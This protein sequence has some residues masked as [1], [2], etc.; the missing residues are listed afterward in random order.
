MN[1]PSNIT[2]TI[3]GVLLTLVSLWYGQNHGLL[4]VAATEEA[5][6]VDNLFN[7]M[8][9]ISTGLFL[10]V[11]GLLVFSLFR[12][13]RRKDDNTDGPPVHG[14]VPLEIFWTA[15]PAVVVLWLSI[16]SFDVYK[17]EG[18]MNPMEHSV[19]H[20]AST[21]DQ[22]AQMPGAALAAPLPEPVETGPA[23]EIQN[24][25][26]QEKATQDPATANVRNEDVPQK[27][28]A[29][30]LGIVSPGVG[31]SPKNR[32]KSPEL[33]VNV[34]GLQYAWIFTYP[35]SGVISGDLH[36]PVGRE[37]RLTMTANDVIHAFWVPE[38]R[39]K[40]DV[41]PGRQTELRFTPKTAGEYSVICAELC[42]AYHS[43]M[44][45]RVI[46]QSPKEY[47]NWL[48]SRKVAANS[49]AQIVAANPTEQS[50]SEF[51]TPHAEAMGFESEIIAP[52]V[53]DSA[54]RGLNARENLQEISDHL[55]SHHHSL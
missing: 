32:G 49:S 41:I 47:D 17:A 27:R 28:E 6:Q 31:A 35:D 50:P 37:V 51:L 38:F 16:Y 36:V 29:S 9:S 46:T 55:A 43:I 25:Q 15:I 2:T 18:G 22:V 54:T 10:L 53:A 45:T 40:Q 26:E 33:T 34:T 44:N 14:N 7:T 4:P 8:M 3:A 11:Q 24:Q 19:A 21:P 52:V 1:I 48:Q 42:G 13:R 12:F 23:S 5:S 20:H 39:L 30:G